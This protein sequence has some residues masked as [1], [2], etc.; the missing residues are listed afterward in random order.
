LQQ[1]EIIWWTLLLKV[2]DLSETIVFV[3]RKKDRQ[4]SFLHTYHH[5]STVIY[6]WLTLRY[7]IHSF[8]MTIIMLNSSVHIIMYSYYFLSTFGSNVQRRLLSF[9]KWITMIQMVSL[10]LISRYIFIDIKYYSYENRHILH[11]WE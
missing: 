4:I 3:L 10:L 8:D 2:I 11:S 1:L 7:F 6:A 9:K 5:I